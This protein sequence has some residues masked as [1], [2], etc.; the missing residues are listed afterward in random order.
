MD[1]NIGLSTVYR[2]LS[3]LEDIGAVTRRS[4]Y[5]VDERKDGRE[6]GICRIELDNGTV[7][8]FSQEQWRQ[9]VKNGLKANGHIADQD[10]KNI[11]VG[12]E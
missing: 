10:V 12:Q 2:M 11:I 6:E 1:K 3:V 9:V 7:L 4:V 8:E 5:R